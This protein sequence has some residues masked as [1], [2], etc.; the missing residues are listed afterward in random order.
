MLSAASALQAK[1]QWESKRN[2]VPTASGKSVEYESP[3]AV[4]ELKRSEQRQ[5]SEHPEDS[6]EDGDV[7]ASVQ[8]YEKPEPEPGVPGERGDGSLPT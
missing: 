2:E 5:A 7:P 3:G 8:Q 6:E 1:D 4:P